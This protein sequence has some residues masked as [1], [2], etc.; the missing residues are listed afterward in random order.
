MAFQ[1]SNQQQWIQIGKMVANDYR[2]PDCPYLFI[3]LPSV[4]R[5]GNPDY[6][7]ENLIKKAV[8]SLNAD[9]RLV[10]EQSCGNI[11]PRKEKNKTQ[12]EPGPADDGYN[13]IP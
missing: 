3:N 8:Q 1:K 4:V 9:L 10:R 5:G 12:G 2:G 6:A 11:T 13:K 7:K